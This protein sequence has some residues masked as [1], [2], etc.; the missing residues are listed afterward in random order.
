MTEVKSAW[1]PFVRR[2]DWKRKNAD[3]RKRGPVEARQ[4][5]RKS[6][7]EGFPSSLPPWWCV[8]LIGLAVLGAWGKWA[9]SQLN[10]QRQ[11]PFHSSKVK[12]A[13]GITL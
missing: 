6:D 11:F 3:E 9:S 13:A 1:L 7:Q 5:A 8:W 12:R 10:C 4:A 2:A